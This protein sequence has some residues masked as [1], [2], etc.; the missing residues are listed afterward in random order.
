M[1]VLKRVLVIFNGEDERSAICDP[2]VVGNIQKTKSKFGK[3]HSVLSS[4]INLFSMTES[5]VQLTL[6]II[7]T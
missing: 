4:T 6:V 5:K 2:Y 3:V 7:H 1:I